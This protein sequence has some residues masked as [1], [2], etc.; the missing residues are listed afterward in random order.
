[1]LFSLLRPGSKVYGAFLDASKAFDKV[2]LNGLITKL[3]KSLPIPLIRI[4]YTWF[5][6]LYCSVAWKSM[7][8]VPF[9]FIC[10]VRQGGILS[11]FLFAIYVD[12]HAHTVV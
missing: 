9:A 7:L 4:L 12:D 6:N 10:G 1:M 5:N 8:G 2:L 3:I 11:P